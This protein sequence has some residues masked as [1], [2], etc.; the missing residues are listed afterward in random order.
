MSVPI[1]ITVVGPSFVGK[2]AMLVTFT[3]RVCPV[4]Y[5]PVWQPRK[6]PLTLDGISYNVTLCDTPGHDQTGFR[7]NH[8][9]S[10]DIFLVCFDVSDP[11]SL[12]IVKE[13]FLPEIKEYS[14]PFILVGTKSDLDFDWIFPAIPIKRGKEDLSYLGAEACVTVS[15]VKYKGINELFQLAVKIAARKKRP[16]EPRLPPKPEY[17]EISFVADPPIIANGDFDI[18]FQCEDGTVPA[19]R[20]ILS[21]KSDHFQALFTSGMSDAK[22]PFIKVQ[23]HSRDTIDLMVKFLYIGTI[24][25]LSVESCLRLIEA[26][27]EYNLKNL[28]LLASRCI[29]KNM[30]ETNVI[31]VYQTA[32]AY[33]VLPLVRNA[34]VCMHVNW[35]LLK[36]SEAKER[37][38]LEQWEAFH[39]AQY[40]PL[41]YYED[42]NKWK[43]QVEEYEEKHKNPPESG[44]RIM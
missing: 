21:D 19:H 33:G 8:Y 13:K 6:I 12:K 37:L 1:K 3:T 22:L 27:E 4:D 24:G 41:Y 7:K 44:C 31:D 23:H 42:L 38:T 15:S 29:T 10:T 40:P 43:K 32:T 28:T 14:V 9:E 11:D 35:T 34:S 36:D 25:K 39:I 5:I 2:T 26:A 20:Q 30:N 18:E 16:V 17:E